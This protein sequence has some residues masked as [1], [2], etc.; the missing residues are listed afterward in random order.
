[1]ECRYLLQQLGNPLIKHTFREQNYAAHLLAKQGSAIQARDTT[2]TFTHPPDFLLQQLLAD[3]QGTIYKRFV[4]PCND[5]DIIYNPADLGNDPL[6]GHS[7]DRSFCT[8]VL[9]TPCNV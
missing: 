3:Q 6:Q 1:L 2:T 5:S 8:N 4:K 7:L 9:L